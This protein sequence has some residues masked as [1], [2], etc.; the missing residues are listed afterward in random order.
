MFQ[1]S[2]GRRCPSR[3]RHPAASESNTTRPWSVDY[4]IPWPIPIAC[5]ARSSRPWRDPG[6][7]WPTPSS[8]PPGTGRAL[9]VVAF[10]PSSLSLRVGPGRAA[11]ARERSHVHT[12]RREKSLFARR[13]KM[14][15]PKKKKDRGICHPITHTCTGT[16]KLR[17][18][19]FRSSGRGFFSRG[20]RD[21][22]AALARLRISRVE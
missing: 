1:N 8:S 22:T 15:E 9:A 7:T 14:R 12:F 10:H 16:G 6:P 2:A 17:A 5:P 21:Q 20:G 4:W 18:F 19:L 11:D 13:R 3:S